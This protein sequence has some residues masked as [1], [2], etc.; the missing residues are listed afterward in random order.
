MIKRIQ[1]APKSQAKKI[2]Q[3]KTDCSSNN[4]KFIVPMPGRASYH[5]QTSQF[6]AK[7]FHKI[8]NTTDDLALE[9]YQAQF[10]MER[11][12]PID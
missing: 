10:L 6:S 7:Q 9:D 2:T 4:I 3:K 12:Y 8:S 5:R 1:S 11:D